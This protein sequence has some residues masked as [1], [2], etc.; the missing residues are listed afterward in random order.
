[1]CVKGGDAFRNG[2]MEFVEILV[3]A[4][5]GEDLTI[6]SEDDSGN[7][8]DGASGAVVAGNPLRSGKGDG[9]GRHGDVDLGVVELA[10]SFREV[11][12]D[13]DGGLLGLQ[14]AGDADGEQS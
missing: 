4:A 1:M 14:Q 3:V 6:G 5:P 10:G 8:V 12:G 11:G 2:D 7:V 13:L 9:A